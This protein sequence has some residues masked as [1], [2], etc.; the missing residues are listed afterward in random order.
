MRNLVNRIAPS[1]EAEFIISDLR[2]DL[3]LRQHGD[4]VCELCRT[5]SRADQILGKTT[6]DANSL[7]ILSEVIDSLCLIDG[8]LKAWCNQ[9]SGD[10][11]YTSLELPTSSPGTKTFF[12]SRLNVPIHVYSSS[13]MAA[14]WNLHRGARILLL[15]GLKNC[16]SRRKQYGAAKPD[17]SELVD[18]DKKTIGSIESLFNDICA[19]VPYLL[20]EVDQKGNLQMPRQC[21]AVGGYYLLWPLCLALFL[22]SIDSVQRE[23]VKR[24]LTYIYHVLGVRE[25][26][27]M[28]VMLR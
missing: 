14:M 21:K 11:R 8:R 10:Y 27:E 3:P 12:E 2:L 24:R 5:L 22:D 6:L 13:T 25:A 26:S 16:L 18:I 4:L 15:H 19:S 9:A 23:W 28:Y 20:G 1:R 17:S 7:S